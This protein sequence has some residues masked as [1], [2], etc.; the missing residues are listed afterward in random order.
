MGRRGAG[1][2]APAGGANVGVGE[3][4]SLLVCRKP[5]NATQRVQGLRAGAARP[6]AP[7][8][9][10][11]R[12]SG[13]CAV[14]SVHCPSA[15]QLGGVVMSSLLGLK[16]GGSTH[17]VGGPP[18]PGAPRAT[19]VP[20]AARAV[21]ATGAAA[22]PASGSTSSA[23]LV[24]RLKAEPPKLKAVPPLPGGA[25]RDGVA[26]PA[27]FRPTTA[28]RLPRYNIRMVRARHR[29]P[30]RYLLAAPILQAMSLS[31]SSQGVHRRRP[32]WRALPCTELR[33]LLR[34]GLH[35]RALRAPM[36]WW[37]MRGRRPELAC[38]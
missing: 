9:T 12:R 14:S 5:E 32:P 27:G 21:N 1:A 37:R 33:A 8:L 13:F 35:Q 10:S 26:A 22:S 36:C 34:W 20:L 28:S 2:N 24:A 23:D 25:S 18:T 4:R 15:R 6:T 29:L 16:V 11:A 19:S 30:P 3:V 31:C 7:E 17:A 38:Q